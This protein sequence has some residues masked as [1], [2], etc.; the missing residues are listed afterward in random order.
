MKNSTN[1]T[2][3]FYVSRF[4]ATTTCGACDR[5][6]AGCC[7]RD[8]D[9]WLAECQIEITEK[10][11]SML[12]NYANLRAA[13]E[14]DILT[15]LANAMES[16]C[17]VAEM[18]TVL[19]AV[20]K[21]QAYRRIDGW[22]CGKEHGYWSRIAMARWA[23]Y[24]YASQFKP[25]DGILPW[26]T[27][28]HLEPRRE[29]EDLRDYA[30]A[31]KRQET[32]TTALYKYRVSATQTAFQ[33]LVKTKRYPVTGG[34]R[35]VFGW[36]SQKA[37][38]RRVKAQEKPLF[39]GGTEVAVVPK[40][41][42][43]DFELW[44]ENLTMKHALIG[45]K[46]VDV[47]PDG[48]CFYRA[49]CVLEGKNEQE[50]QTLKN[51]VTAHM[52]YRCETGDV[53]LYSNDEF[54]KIVVYQ[55][56]DNVWAEDEVVKTYARLREVRVEVLQETRDMA[57]K[58]KM[59]TAV[60]NRSGSETRSLVLE[61]GHY[62]ALVLN[63]EGK[64]ALEKKKAH[65]KAEKVERKVCVFEENASRTGS[66]PTK[67]V[68][69]GADG[70]LQRL[71]KVSFDR[72]TPDTLCALHEAE[73][74]PG[75]EE[76]APGE[77]VA[78]TKVESQRCNGPILGVG[79]VEHK[80]NIG[81]SVEHR[82]TPK[83]DHRYRPHKWVSYSSESIFDHKGPVLHQCKSKGKNV[84]GLA[85]LL[86]ADMPKSN[87]Y[88]VDNRA[89]GQYEEFN[90]DGK[91]YVN[92][93]AQR[94]GG[95]ANAKGDTK[96]QRL[97]W[98][99]NAVRNYFNFRKDKDVTIGFPLLVGCGLAGGVWDDYLGLITNLAEVYCRRVV[100]YSGEENRHH[101]ANDPALLRHKPETDTAKRH[102]EFVNRIIDE[103]FTKDRIREAA[104]DV[105]GE[106]CFDESKCGKFNEK[107]I[108]AAQDKIDIM[109]EAGDIPMR[110]STTKIEFVAKEGK[111]ARAVVDNGIEAFVIMNGVARIIEQ[112]TYGA[113]KADGKGG[114]VFRK[115]SIKHK[116][117][118]KCITEFCKKLD[119]KGQYAWEID[120]TAMECHERAPGTMTLWLRLVQ[121]VL[122]QIEASWA[123][124]NC[125]KLQMRLDYDE[126]FG[127]RIKMT[128]TGMTAPGGKKNVTLSF[129]DMYLDSGWLLTSWLNFMQE[130]TATV[131]CLTSTPGNYLAYNKATQEFWVEREDFIPRF[132]PLPLL[133]NPEALWGEAVWSTVS[134]KARIFIRGMFEGDD[135]GG[136]ITNNGP[137][138]QQQAAVAWRMADLGFSA[139][140]KVVST[141]RLEIVGL[142]IA[143][144]EGAYDASVPV[145][146]NLKR[147]LSKMGCHA[148]ATNLKEDQRAAIG[149][150]RLYSLASMFSQ[151]IPAMATAFEN[152]AEVE[153]RACGKLAGK[154]TIRVE[155]YSDVDKAFS[156]FETDSSVSITA[157]RKA[158]FGA[159]GVCSYEAREQT[160]AIANSYE[161]RV[162]K[163]VG[164]MP[165]D[166][167]GRLELFAG[168]LSDWNGTDHAA[169]RSFLPLQ[170]M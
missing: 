152:L 103:V 11:F 161:M 110:K 96:K 98:F 13:K 61:H 28:N 159:K 2:D 25:A 140:F 142:H 71:S 89:L 36:T 127:M 104:D 120:Q 138:E 115:I 38:T 53:G 79:Y 81:W 48:N 18:T 68:V 87:S 75:L 124:R 111:S 23:S 132:M 153:Y 27:R 93:Y 15:A 155:R 99:K 82:T 40:E 136:T 137:K 101:P 116:E 21:L 85:K 109:S 88:N 73:V 58:A 22:F 80:D 51:E 146:P 84:E 59:R 92:I 6:V 133:E 57:G 129:D 151:S 94:Y 143:M 125:G 108:R 121:K 30:I 54:R 47:V 46:I 26:G 118:V 150:A 33:K 170:L 45:K 114:G 16:R 9:P 49:A 50:W 64:K 4:F 69:D 63:D 74:L 148:Q 134:K 42:A 117:R 66:Y 76:G 31:T 113:P 72:V 144:T 141:G 43:R 3:K 37:P 145:I 14:R 65:E 102:T 62:R 29:W 56:G 122:T 7:A 135:G 167:V 8:N 157:V 126:E 32:E 112:M 1:R 78:F 83:A 131:C 91:T 106:T 156:E 39:P 147:Y 86:F 166:I 154:A 163:G 119:A 160:L 44:D 100:F 169:A 168:Y 165:E 107:E 130:F 123:G 77:K 139:K 70:K 95:K 41:E 17:D 55:R 10:V 67:I 20:I 105:F 60:C 128:I 164:E 52:Q 34:T 162:G 5:N 158:Y 90:E 19:L 35:R 149:A 97:L 12:L 24:A